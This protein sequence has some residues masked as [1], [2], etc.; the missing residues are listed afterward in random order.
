MRIS[1][2][3]VSIILLSQLVSGPGCSGLRNRQATGPQVETITAIG[4]QPRTRSTLAGASGDSTISSRVDPLPGKRSEGRI[5]GRVLDDRGKVVPNALVRLAVDDT[6]K[7]RE[8]QVW[9]DKEGAFV[10]DGLRPGVEYDLIAEW[11]DRDWLLLGR[12]PALA[13]DDDIQIV[14]KD[15]RVAWEGTS[16]SRIEAANRQNSVSSRDDRDDN[17]RSES[18]YE[19]PPIGDRIN[20]ISRQAEAEQE[21]SSRIRSQQ[22]TASRSE[23]KAVTRLAGWVPSD[24]IDR[25]V[26]DSKLEDSQYNPLPPAIERRPPSVAPSEPADS[27]PN[28]P[29]AFS[30]GNLPEPVGVGS[31][32]LQDRAPAPPPATEVE[33]IADPPLTLPD[34]LNDV[35]AEGISSR[36]APLYYVLEGSEAADVIPFPGTV[37]EDSRREAP[38]MAIA[39]VPRE[40]RWPVD[41]NRDA[42]AFA[43]GEDPPASA[44]P[45]SRSNSPTDGLA[46]G[47]V[48]PPV[49][50]ES[51]GS[52]PRARPVERER[53]REPE[54]EPA[55]NA[56]LMDQTVEPGSRVEEP[57]NP[58]TA[59]AFPEIDELPAD[60]KEPANPP[61]PTPL[62]EPLE[63]ES[64][65]KTEEFPN[66]PEMPFAP[67][68]SPSVNPEELSETP[69]VPNGKLTWNDMPP[70][71]EVVVEPKEPEPAL[72]PSNPPMVA[73]EPEIIPS[74][75]VVPAAR[76][77][78]K[79]EEERSRPVRLASRMG[80]GALGNFK[81]GARGNGTGAVVPTCAFDA[82]NRQL[83]DFVLP[84]LQGQPFQFESLEAE[85]VI[86]VFWG[87][88]CE[89]C[90]EVLAHLTLLQE[91]FG[92]QGLRVIGIAHEPDI[93]PNQRAKVVEEAAQK[94]GIA[95]PVLLGS[96]EEPA[97]LENALKIQNYPTILLLD[98]DK[99]IRWRES[100]ATPAILSRLDRALAAAVN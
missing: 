5:S 39:S 38:P 66:V 73:T 69:R 54:P 70:P 19:P 53:E 91:R 21:L 77:V 1:T 2:L 62:P 46:A 25:R 17:P 34:Q 35:E 100:G 14:V 59:P 32:P 8:I 97:P 4:E 80:L 33:P 16:V 61:E 99:V 31:E 50:S 20:A 11:E 57:P 7:G 89:G 78:V 43:F 71:G 23:D 56:P 79:E 82:K 88:W 67:P 64:E 74:D 44:L 81:A 41:P 26:P 75:P 42:G 76:S 28:Q 86:L 52:A 47:P 55:D 6:S 22:P 24:S 51:W 94:L 18:R 13:P 29:P 92:P 60:L 72:L 90:Q 65:G 96:I 85:Q 49:G 12:A 36:S 95:F 48:P 3:G 83:A 45:K 98:R 84:D 15:T 37:Q 40:D 30:R 63:P 68:A 9:T 58:P 10:L 27:R 87:S 93:D